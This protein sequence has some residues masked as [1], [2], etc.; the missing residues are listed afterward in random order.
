[1]IHPVVVRTWKLSASEERF[2]QERQPPLLIAQTLLLPCRGGACS[3]RGPGKRKKTIPQS[4]SLTAPFTQGSLEGGTSL[5]ASPKKG[6]AVAARRLMRWYCCFPHRGKC[7]AG[8]IGGK[9]NAPCR[10]PMAAASP[11]GG[12]MKT[13]RGACSS[14]SPS[15]LPRARGS[16]RASARLMRSLTYLSDARKWGPHPPQAV[17]LPHTRG[18]QK[19]A[20][21]IHPGSVSS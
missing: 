14:R 12:G 2:V 7:P 16:C 15:W 11:R 21:D 13:A 8:A 1:M 6:E 10:R 17:P 9:W 20:D 4:A 5:M 3:S 19:Q 18:R